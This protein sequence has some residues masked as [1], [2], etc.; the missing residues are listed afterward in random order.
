MSLELDEAVELTNH[1]HPQYLL[2]L[3]LAY[4]FLERKNVP[5]EQIFLYHDLILINQAS[6]TPPKFN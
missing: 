6:Y 2:I 5:T 3:F 4:Q 1:F